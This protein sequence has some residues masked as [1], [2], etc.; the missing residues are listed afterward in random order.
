MNSRPVVLLV[1][2]GRFLFWTSQYDF[3]IGLLYVGKALEEA[4][5][6]VEFLDLR[7]DRLDSFQPKDYLFVGIT[8]MTGRMVKD[9]L[10]VARRMRSFNPSIPIM[11][12]GV[13]ASMLP[14]ETLRSSLVDYVCI[15]EGDETVKEFAAALMAGKSVKG[16][17]G[18]GYKEGGEPKVNPPRP[19]VDL[20]RLDFK[21][22]YERCVEDP[23][24]VPTFAINTS[25]GCPFR[26]GFCYNQSFNKRTYRKKTAELVVEEIEY[27]ARRFKS[28]SITFSG[29]DEFFIDVKRA[30][31]ISELLLQ[32][33]IKTRWGGFC[34]FNTL[35]QMEDDEIRLFQRAGCQV[36]SFGGESGSQRILDDI[37]QKD[38]KVE[39]IIRGC[40]RLDRLGM[41]H[42]VSFMSCFP[43]ETRQDLE[44]TFSLIEKLTASNR[45]IFLNGIFMFVPLPG[46]P[47]FDM[48]KNDFGFK[49]PSTLEE[50]GKYEVPDIPFR[51]RTWHD[52]DHL[53]FCR[54][55]FLTSGYPYYFG[56]DLDSR[57]AYEK[58]RA[59][60]FN[61]YRPQLLFYLFSKLQRLRWR[62]RF[63]LMP[64]DHLV[65][66]ILK[67]WWLKAGN[68]YRKLKAW[69]GFS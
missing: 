43:T 23:S 38:L 8:M 18:I 60:S 40:E 25:R 33:N 47:L 14:E 19:F 66:E 57:E 31:R 49:P 54:G 30:V 41:P 28:E 61:N 37:I 12:G 48:V 32:K 22:P 24:K 68:A 29:D 15:G 59:L 64:L 39:Q 5:V 9:G 46:T 69:L 21:L 20:N 7:K 67:G 58:A 63:F 27:I 55:V 35:E 17:R 65:F 13:H 50:W 6:D 42:I 56:K 52:R 16:I 11:I 3:P 51:Y 36:L 44:M 62:K 1:Y 34:R 45:R 26:C 2:P 4:G 10:E 53:K